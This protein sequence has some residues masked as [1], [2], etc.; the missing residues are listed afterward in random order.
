[1]GNAHVCDEVSRGECGICM[2][3][4]VCKQCY[5]GCTDKESCDRIP[6]C[7]VKSEDLNVFFFCAGVILAA[8]ALLMFCCL[9][10]RRQ[11]L[12]SFDAKTASESACFCP[13]CGTAQVS[14]AHSAIFKCA[15]RACGAYLNARAATR[16]MR[17]SEPPPVSP[18]SRAHSGAAGARRGDAGLGGG[19]SDGEN[20]S[21]GSS[22]PSASEPLY[23][24]SVI[25]LVSGPGEGFLPVA[26]GPSQ[27]RRPR[28]AARTHQRSQR[29][30]PTRTEAHMPR[31][32][33]EGR[34]GGDSD[35]DDGDDDDGDGDDL[36]EA[37]AD[38]AH[39]NA[40]RDGSDSDGTAVTEVVWDSEGAASLTY[41]SRD[42]TITVPV[43]PP[44]RGDGDRGF[45]RAQR[46]AA[47]AAAA[48]AVAEPSRMSSLRQHSRS[49]ALPL[50]LRSPGRPAQAHGDRRQSRTHSRGHEH[51]R[52]RPSPEPVSRTGAASLS[53]GAGAG[54]G[55]ARPRLAG[56]S[57]FASQRADTAVTAAA[58]GTGAVGAGAGVQ[59]PPAQQAASGYESEPTAASSDDDTGG[60]SGGSGGS[61]RDRRRGVNGR[62]G[63]A[64][65][66]TGS[67]D[68]AGASV[69]SSWRT[70]VSGYSDAEDDD[71]ED[72]QLQ[73][74]GILEGSL[75]PLF[76]SR[77]NDYG[78]R[79]EHAGRRPR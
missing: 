32:G 47:A 28:M 27:P 2:P 22:S 43:R 76:A 57:G 60:G 37:G 5:Y 46:R 29:P 33:G 8:V 70:Y 18:S 56:H 71:A 52:G 79:G 14:T 49:S 55:L 77:I 13:M 78:R 67:G 20:R 61:D 45:S 39:N 63:R 75:A 3:W 68:R 50:P 40:D 31:A 41:V 4:Q 21:G 54:T 36:A 44:G 25:R 66:G 69:A 72:E 19:D 73:V 7:E 62:G 59:Q 26:I 53:R 34:Y 65:A 48:A 17:G 51:G 64:G 38:G 12:V 1:M 10:R 74:Q 58:A 30:H 15:N 16:R 23:E 42:A 11:F 24:P 6:V 35:D 9:F